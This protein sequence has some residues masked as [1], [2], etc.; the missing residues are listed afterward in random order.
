VTVIMGQVEVWELKAVAETIG[1]R[2]SQSIQ[3]MGWRC[4]QL[5][6]PR[7]DRKM[8]DKFCSHSNQRGAGGGCLQ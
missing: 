1:R 4:T 6:E 8:I 7:D 2:D 5:W 3:G